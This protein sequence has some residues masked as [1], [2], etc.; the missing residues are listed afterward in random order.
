MPP[1]GIFFEEEVGFFLAEEFLGVEDCPGAT[2]DQALRAAIW[3]AA[4]ISVLV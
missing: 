4:A 2:P 1:A 3:K